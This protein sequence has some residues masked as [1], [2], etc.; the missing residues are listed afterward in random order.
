VS[1]ISHTFAVAITARLRKAH[2][3][4]VT[5]TVRMKVGEQIV[6]AVDKARAVLVVYMSSR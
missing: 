6:F 1:R 4:I 2:R 3:F 5:G